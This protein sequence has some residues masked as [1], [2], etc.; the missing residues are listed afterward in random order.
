[1]LL[2][3]L[4]ILFFWNCQIKFT[5]FDCKF[6]IRAILF[7]RHIYIKKCL[8]IFHPHS[9]NVNNLSIFSRKITR[10]LFSSPGHFIRKTYIFRLLGPLGDCDLS[11]LTRLGTHFTYVSRIFS[12]F[13]LPRTQ[14]HRER[15]YASSYVSTSFVPS[16]KWRHLE[17]RRA[18]TRL[19]W[20]RGIFS[21]YVAEN[22]ASEFHPAGVLIVNS[23]PPETRLNESRHGS[24]L[25]DD[26]LRLPL[27]NPKFI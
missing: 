13:S 11:T 8:L 17:I 20:Q 9:S 4:N 26:V 22:G 21:A 3:T 12:L 5:F 23:S 27:L 19:E 25:T 7:L 15:A 16:D 24:H 14:K 10:S 18:G 6:H 2:Y 1:M